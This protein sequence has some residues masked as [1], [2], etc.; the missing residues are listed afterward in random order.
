MVMMM[1]MMMMMM[2]MIIVHNNGDKGERTRVEGQMLGGGFH[3]LCRC[4]S[5]SL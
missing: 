1:M 5:A 3:A 4:F 2:I